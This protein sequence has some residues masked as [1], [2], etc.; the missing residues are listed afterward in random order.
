MI[1]IILYNIIIHKIIDFICPF[2]FCFAAPPLPF[3]Y[4]CC[5]TI[6]ISYIQRQLIGDSLEKI[7][8]SANIIDKN[9]TSKFKNIE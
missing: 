8:S 9:F 2:L 3:L 5:Q 7:G 4:L 6:F 1:Y